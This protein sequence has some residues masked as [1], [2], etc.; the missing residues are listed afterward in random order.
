MSSFRESRSPFDE[1][2][3][4]TATY[5]NGVAVGI[6]VVGGVAPLINAVLPGGS[7]SAKAGILSG[8]GLVCIIASI[9]I[10]LGAQWY[11]RRELSR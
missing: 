9:D 3:K 6:A 11:L 8:L 4:L 7:F 1:A 5:A 10:H 2:A